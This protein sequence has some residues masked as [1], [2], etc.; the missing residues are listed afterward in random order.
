M[1][2]TARFAGPILP[3]RDYTR[4]IHTQWVIVLCPLRRAHFIRCSSDTT[5]LR[6]ATNVTTYRRYR[7]GNQEG[8]YGR[9][10]DEYG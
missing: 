9:R 2:S 5:S 8:R 4:L 6:N 10:R 7:H 1:L 3:R